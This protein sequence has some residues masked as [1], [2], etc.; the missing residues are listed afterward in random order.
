MKTLHRILKLIY[1]VTTWQ[2]D[3]IQVAYWDCSVCPFFT[4][5]ILRSFSVCVYYNFQTSSWNVCLKNDYI[6][7]KNKEVSRKPYQVLGVDKI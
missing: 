5:K 7:S 3:S 4:G 2:L 6:L 1:T